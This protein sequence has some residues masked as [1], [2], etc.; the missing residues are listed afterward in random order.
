VE[1]YRLLRKE[2]RLHDAALGQRTFLVAANKI[3]LPESAKNLAALRAA[4]L[5]T[6]FSVSA[7]TVE[8]LPDLISSIR[9]LLPS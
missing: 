2:L 5:K 1:D 6:I 8:G 7:T 3:D 9:D 4:A